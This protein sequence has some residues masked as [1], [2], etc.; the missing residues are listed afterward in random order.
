MSVSTFSVSV[1]PYRTSEHRFFWSGQD[2]YL[3]VVSRILYLSG[4]C[5]V[6]PVLILVYE[7]LGTRV[8]RI[9][10]SFGMP[11]GAVLLVGTTR[12]R[13]S[14]INACTWKMRAVGGPRNCLD[15]VQRLVSVV[16]SLAILP[17][18]R[19]FGVEDLPD[20]VVAPRSVYGSTVRG[21][22]RKLSPVGAC[23]TSQHYTAD[24]S[25]TDC[26]YHLR[27]SVYRVP[28]MV[29]L[30][31][32]LSQLRVC[33]LVRRRFPCSRPAL[34]APEQAKGPNTDPNNGSQNDIRGTD[35]STCG[36][37]FS[38]RTSENRHLNPQ[39]DRGFGNQWQHYESQASAPA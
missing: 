31:S 23:G 39:N 7:V 24:D 17:S 14:M 32:L 28:F 12:H 8:I 15:E 16:V 20:L 21:F 2:G 3:I 38:A 33:P 36:F 6:V 30:R 11:L 1:G 10:D 34:C 19:W 26:L 25:R 5:Q 27:R 13:D 18:T 29:L 22:S 9:Y 4:T 35:V 37:R